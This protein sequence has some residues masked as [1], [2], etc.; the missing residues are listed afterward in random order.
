MSSWRSCCATGL[1]R[2]EFER[3]DAVVERI[4]R[5]AASVVQVTLGTGRPVPYR[6]GQYFE[7]G[8]PGIAPN[9]NFSAANRPGSD[10][11]VFDVRLYPGGK[12]GEHVTSRLRVGDRVE[13]IGPYGHFGLTANVHRPAICVAGGTGLAPIK[14]MVDET[15]AERS[16]R[17]ITL[18]YGARSYDDLY[19][20]GLLERWS[21]EYPGFDYRIA[22]SGEAADGAWGG[23]RGPVTDLVADAVY[24]G[25]GAEAFLCGPPPMI[26]AA[27]AVLERIGVERS[28]MYADR[29]SPAKP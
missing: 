10:R 2:R 5:V 22:L 1:P 14:A 25:F 4:E 18:F 13:L 6:A 16:G 7:W 17:S 19:D 9:R 11:I 21:A 23:A 24:D 8:L 28:D 12:V 26:D 3:L 20:I 27:M 15:V 29:F